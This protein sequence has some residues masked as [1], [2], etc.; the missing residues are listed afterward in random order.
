MASQILVPLRGSDR[1][2]QLLPYIEKV[3][4]PGL[5]VTF[6]VH[7][8]HPAFHELIGQLLAIHTGVTPSRLPGQ[9]N[10]AEIVQQQMRLA[11]QKVAPA[12][13]ALRNK[14]VEVSVTVFAGSVRKVVREYAAM[15]NVHLV[16]MPHSRGDW[17][18]RPVRKLISLFHFFKPQTLAPVLLLH[19]SSIV[20]RFP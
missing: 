15:G 16:L 17:L 7:Y 4:Q 8:G 13:L 11:V 12:G 3:V 1:I 14:G 19:P 5:K 2:E 10:H 20:G 18:P 6:L 9:L